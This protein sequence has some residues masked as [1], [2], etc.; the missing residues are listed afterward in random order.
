MGGREGVEGGWKM[1]AKSG[2]SN[3]LHCRER[4]ED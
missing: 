2:G 3:H 1:D 4:E